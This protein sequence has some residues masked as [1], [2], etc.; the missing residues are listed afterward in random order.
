MGEDYKTLFFL[1]I[2]YGIIIIVYLAG[3]TMD[4]LDK[5]KER[6][7]KKLIIYAVLLLVP[8]LFFLFICA[9]IN[10]LVFGSSNNNQ[11]VTENGEIKE[12]ET[13]ENL[14]FKVLCQNC[15]EMSEMSGIKGSEFMEKMSEITNLYN[16]LEFEKERMDELDYI[17]LAT[18]IGYEKK[19][20]A[21]IFQDAT[22][23]GNW[24]TEENL[25]NRDINHFPRISDI[26]V[27]NAQKFYKWASVM[28]G[29]PYALPDINLRGLLGNL[30][31]GKV[32]TTCVPG[33]D[34]KSPDEQEDELITNI[35][36]VE[37][38]LSGETIQDPSWWDS[39]LS[40]FGIKYATDDDVL[41]KRLEKMFDSLDDPDSDYADLVPYIGLDNYEPEKKCPAGQM[42]KHTYTKFMNY[43]QYKVYLE[44][45]YIP[46]N[47]I[48]CDECYYKNS[49]DYNKEV[50]T[51]TILK[52]IFDLAEYNR[53]YL[54]MTEIDYDNILY[55]EQIDA[56]DLAYFS[57]PLKNACRVTSPYTE[58]RGSYPHLAV[59]TTMSNSSDFSLYAIADGV[60]EAVN[61]YTTD[62]Y[63]YDETVQTCL[64]VPNQNLSGIEIWIKHTVNGK[65]YRARYVHISPD[66]IEVNVGDTVEKGQKI[67][68]MGTTGC[69][70]GIHLHFELY[71]NGESINPILLFKQCEASNISG[72]LKIKTTDNFVTPE[73]CMVGDLTLDEVIA[74]LIKKDNSNAS[75]S[76][77]YIKSLAIVIRTKLMK[78]TN[79]CNT[80]ISEN[81]N[82]DI[83]NN[84][85][86]LLIYTYVIDTQG[87]VLNY[88][89]EVLDKVDYK[90]FPCEQ[91]PINGW[92]TPN[93]R[94]R[95][96]NT[97]GIA[98]TDD[99][100]YDY[101]VSEI[102]N[103]NLGCAE[104]TNK[105]GDV[106]VEFNTMPEAIRD[107]KD[108]FGNSYNTAIISI[109]R[110]SITSTAR[111]AQDKFSTIA[112]IY[113]NSI[114]RTYTDILFDFY[115]SKTKSI[116]HPNKYTGLV[117]ISTSPGLIDAKISV[118]NRNVN[119]SQSFVYGE[120]LPG[121]NRIPT[122]SMDEA[123]LQ[124]INQHIE[125]YIDTA[126]KN[127]IAKGD[128]NP[129]RA[130]VMA[131][132]YWLIYNPFYR[133][134]YQWGKPLAHDNYDGIGWDPSWSSIRGVECQNF[135]LWS[136]WNAGA[137][138]TYPDALV[139]QH[140]TVYLDS[141]NKNFTVK[142]V[143]DAGIEVGDILRK[144]AP[145]VNGIRT[146]NG[147]WAIVMEVNYEKCYLDV[148]HAVSEQLDTKITR[149]YCGTEF[150]Y[151]H[152]YK[153]PAFYQ[154]DA[155][156]A[157]V[158]K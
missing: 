32:V 111:Y 154:D 20:D 51:K 80:P 84:P 26:D 76:P 128:I 38:K 3:E 25:T 107:K 69:S 115:G 132:A 136:L 30:I 124:A 31:T 5:I 4:F 74:G 71:M 152:L 157:S 47:Y 117:D 86:D 88:S 137:K 138:S 112:A 145:Y 144:S 158:G 19:M 82:I 140:S 61:K 83:E 100:D 1:C 40:I 95:V 6:S 109:P 2:K 134:Q 43:E 118:I 53:K 62:T 131:A 151:Q 58:L 108:E 77:E 93:N 9:L 98:D 50:L 123:E 78:E 155:W 125:N 150:N 23:F 42:P 102:Q 110:S 105:G 126:E 89:G 48:N 135:V 46:E 127:A 28:L 29:T 16:K 37:K 143:L 85:R 101:V 72:R 24:V 130:R 148:A 149:Y 41:K 75:N 81:V 91:L 56:G 141:G 60:V 120:T 65:E 121:T 34:N 70:T 114:G 52:E 13:G 99:L 12:G 116:S 119:T 156:K 94:A 55:G 57:S 142:Q 68:N 14:V 73:K 122:G 64:N 15:K 49:S 153:L 18:T 146:K 27:D 45:V 17:L 133:V 21:K 147:H 63:E 129:K 54:Q 66:G 33:N 36:N 7:K 139:L 35:I 103:Y 104:Y 96:L 90:K 67:A 92:S 106:V 39:I 10:E 44:K 97:L 22:K 79:W 113:Y 11:S 8:L 87:M 59:D